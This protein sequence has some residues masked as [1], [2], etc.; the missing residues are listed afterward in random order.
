LY[1][2]QDSA[3][4]AVD[5]GTSLALWPQYE[6]LF[7]QILR[8]FTLPP[9][10]ATALPAATAMF[11]T[12]ATL[13]ATA[14]PTDSAATGEAGPLSTAT[15]TT[16]VTGTI[17]GT[18]ASTATT[19]PPSSTLAIYTNTLAHWAIAYP[20]EW[21]VLDSDAS[22]MH[23]LLDS[24][25]A[26]SPGCRA[27]A[28]FVGEDDTLLELVDAYYMDLE[29]SWES[30]GLALEIYS[31]EEVTLP[32]GE[33]GIE[34]LAAIEA[35]GMIDSLHVLRDR[36]SY[37]FYCWAVEPAW[38]Q[39]EAAFGQIIRSFTLL[40]P[41]VSQSGE[42]VDSAILEQVDSI[43]ATTPY[44]EDTFD[45]ETSL[46][47]PIL[48]EGT[49]ALRFEKVDGQAQICWDEGDY[50]LGLWLLFNV[51][52]HDFYAEFEVFNLGA[53]DGLY[54]GMGYSASSGVMQIGITHEDGNIVSSIVH[55]TDDAPEGE[56]LQADDTMPTSMSEE[57]AERLRLGVLAA[58]SKLIVLI[59][60][61]VVTTV[62]AA[63]PA[64][65]AGVTLFAGMPQGCYL[66]Y[67]NFRLWEVD[68][69]EI[70]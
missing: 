31:Q 64:D 44:F 24:D 28:S 42:L 50:G 48:P 51:Y 30:E 45:A 22:D 6:A 33:V 36:T 32:S 23:F 10:E 37:I 2:L 14:M 7:D 41:Q 3:T 70:P 29:K 57:Q 35:N 60:D 52:V 39:W 18:V 49:S 27:M 55:Y 62:D 46:W 66:A 34:V 21:S 68:G 65:D 25:D 47:I 9:L 5:C 56:P 4:S 63:A 16:T 19:A 61:D 59:D 13:T 40:P 15:V 43:R 11:T 20:E 53:T 54:A 17:T 67:D 8:S 12:T 26:E 58:G 38:P 69:L 1:A